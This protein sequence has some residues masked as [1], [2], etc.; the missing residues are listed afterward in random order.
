MNDTM[1]RD[2]WCI[3]SK[4]MRRKYQRRWFTTD[5][6]VAAAARRLHKTINISSIRGGSTNYPDIMGATIVRDLSD[7][8]FR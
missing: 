5:E 1:S 8:H 4:Y 6:V 7:V 3:L 2:D